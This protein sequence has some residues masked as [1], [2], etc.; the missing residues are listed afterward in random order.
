MLRLCTRRTVLAVR[1][2]PRTLY[3]DARGVC[4]S[5]V[6]AVEEDNKDQEEEEEE[7]DEEE[8]EN[9]TAPQEVIEKIAAHAETHWPGLAPKTLPPGW[10]N[11]W[12]TWENM[13]SLFAPSPFYLMLPQLLM[14][15]LRFG[16]KPWT[17]LSPYFDAG[18]PVPPNV[19][20]VAYKDELVVI[21]VGDA[22][23]LMD[24][25]SGDAALYAVAPGSDGFTKGRPIGEDPLGRSLCDRI[26]ARD[27]SVREELCK[28]GYL[29]FVP[30]A[31]TEA[32]EAD[33]VEVSETMEEKMEEM[34]EQFQMIDSVMRDLGLEPPENPEEWREFAEKHVDAIAVRLEQME[35]ERLEQSEQQEQQAAAQPKGDQRTIRELQVENERLRKQVDTLSKRQKAAWYETYYDEIDDVNKRNPLDG[36]GKIFIEEATACPHLSKRKSSTS[37]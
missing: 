18:G 31:T 14:F 19:G 17:G 36:H 9:F 2:L 15:F 5:A 29:P 6:E 23:Y 35:V 27:D 37:S 10:S 22:S 33:A 20:V 16:V 11:D 30:E 25:A 32:Q 24:L 28:N 13:P 4:P 34:Q 3:P 21:R 26:I 12:Q 1:T 8:Y 7:D